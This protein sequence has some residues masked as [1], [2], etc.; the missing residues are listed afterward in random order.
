MARY[1]ST[2]NARL[3][4]GGFLLGAALFV[5]GALGGIVAPMLVGPLPGWEQT[6]FLY[7]EIIGTI[8]GFFSPVLF[9]I[10]FPLTS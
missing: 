7:A 1:S 4:K 6:L 9:G 2:D 8:V 3:A 5:V 10:V